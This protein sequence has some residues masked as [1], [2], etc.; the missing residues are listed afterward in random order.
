MFMPRQKADNERRQVVSHDINGCCAC[1]AL[2][3]GG[4]PAVRHFDHSHVPT[5]E[6]TLNLQLHAGATVTSLTL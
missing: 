4:P 6:K 1:C 5:L 2:E 3:Q